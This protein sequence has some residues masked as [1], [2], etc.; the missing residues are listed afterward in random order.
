MEPAPA[1]PAGSPRGRA[2]P[3]AYHPVQELCERSGPD[4]PAAQQQSS[5]V[6]AAS[7][8]EDA[9]EPSVRAHDALLAGSAAAMHKLT[10]LAPA[11]N[12]TA[13]QQSSEGP[14]ASSQEDRADLSMR[15][16]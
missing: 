4:D 1:T 8:Q 15:S 16:L 6:P 3:Y 14:T 7:K 10:C 11:D 13:Q 12:R 9:A 5:E 2:Y